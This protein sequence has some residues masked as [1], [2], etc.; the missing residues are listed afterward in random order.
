MSGPDLREWALISCFLHA[1]CSAMCVG[2]LAS[3]VVMVSFIFIALNWNPEPVTFTVFTVSFH[4]IKLHHE[5]SSVT[6]WCLASVQIQLEWHACCCHYAPQTMLALIS[7]WVKLSLGLFVLVW[8]LR[9]L[10]ATGE[11]PA[12]VQ[13][14]D[15]TDLGQ[16]RH[17]PQC[18]VNKSR[19][20]GSGTSQHSLGPS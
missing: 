20:Y 7:S 6:G 8:R 18:E 4:K 12:L 13:W 9:K 5:C 1:H 17:P 3:V 16:W 19:C 10:Q 2:I 15:Y 14:G 11:L